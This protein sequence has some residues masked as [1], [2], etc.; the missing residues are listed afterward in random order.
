MGWY[1]YYAS[2]LYGQNIQ[3]IFVKA[4]ELA[5]DSQQST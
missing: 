3:Q 5:I 2:A 4:A 1:F